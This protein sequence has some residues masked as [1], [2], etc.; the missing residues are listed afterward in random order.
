MVV[1]F[2]NGHEDLRKKKILYT[3]LTDENKIVFVL[4]SGMLLQ[5][6]SNNNAIK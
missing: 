4:G 2:N 6:I 5:E 3:T 1:Q